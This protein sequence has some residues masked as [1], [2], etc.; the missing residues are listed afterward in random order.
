M[1]KFDD[2]IFDVWFKFIYVID[3]ILMLTFNLNIYK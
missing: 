3:F 1:I 2:M